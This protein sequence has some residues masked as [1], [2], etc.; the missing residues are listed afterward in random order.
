MHIESQKIIENK[1]NQAFDKLLSI[2]EEEME[3]LAKRLSDLEIENQKL[4]LIISNL[5][6]G[7]SVSKKDFHLHKINE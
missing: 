5:R 1:I 7:K 2:Y 4:K 3:R 6:L